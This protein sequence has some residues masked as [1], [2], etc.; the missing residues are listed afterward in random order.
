MKTAIRIIAILISVLLL[1]VAP[2]VADEF[3]VSSDLIGFDSGDGMMAPGTILNP[4]IIRDSSGREI[5]SMET[6]L[7]GLDGNDGLM[8]PGTVLN[9]YR[10]KWND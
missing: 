5:G 6:D 10:I 8:A 2:A 4:L 7:I 1:L 9:P 3:T